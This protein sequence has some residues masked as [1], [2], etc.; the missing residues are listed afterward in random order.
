MSYC[1]LFLFFISQLKLTVIDLFS[2]SYNL[3]E[4]VW[5]LFSESIHSF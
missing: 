4:K 5:H 2:I 1:I 3:P